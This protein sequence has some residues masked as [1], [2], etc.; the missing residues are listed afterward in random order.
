[1]PPSKKIIN[2]F[3]FLKDETVIFID[4]ITERSEKYEMRSFQKFITDNSVDPYCIFLANREEGFVTPL[5]KYKLTSSKTKDPIKAS[6]RSHND[7]I[8]LCYK[9]CIEMFKKK[10]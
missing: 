1:M 4:L 6:S 9:V 5:F 8:D 2:G 3:G 10:D 7:L